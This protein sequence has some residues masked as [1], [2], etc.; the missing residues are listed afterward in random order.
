MA[1]NPGGIA[2]DDGPGGDVAGDHRPHADDRVV[3]DGHAVDHAHPGAQP[4][5][6]ADA[7]TPGT[8]WL[9]THQRGGVHTVVKGV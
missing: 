3:T 8:H 2:G 7:D 9:F 1:D 6:P 5:I 4:D